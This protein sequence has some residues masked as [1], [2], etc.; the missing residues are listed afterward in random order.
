MFCDMKGGGWE[1]GGDSDAID[2]GLLEFLKDNGKNGVVIDGVVSWIEMQMEVAAD[3]IWKAQA[4]A[5]YSDDEV[6]AGKKALWDAAMKNIGDTQPR[7]Q[8]KS[9]RWSD[10]DD[11]HKALIK[12]K[13][14][15][16]LPLILASSRMLPEDQFLMEYQLMPTM[17]MLLA[18]SQLR[19]TA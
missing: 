6:M 15:N 13:C 7:R 3:G 8:G 4:E 2:R 11:I 12:L 17:M 5:K 10:I 14:V 16:A 19:K 1:G 18:E 9:K